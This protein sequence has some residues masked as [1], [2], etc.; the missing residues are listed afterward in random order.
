MGAGASCA[1]SVSGAAASAGE[2]AGA[3]VFIGGG[4]LCS[5]DAVKVSSPMVVGLDHRVGHWASMTA[6][7]N[8]ALDV[9]EGCDKSA[10]LRSLCRPLGPLRMPP[11]F[12]NAS[13]LQYSGVLPVMSVW[14]NVT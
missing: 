9:V 8:Y 6:S 5:F 4:H 14:L 12:S 13:C 2:A 1:E 10:R 3:D 7:A 11:E